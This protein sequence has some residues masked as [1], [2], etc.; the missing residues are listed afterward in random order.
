[1]S[2][3]SLPDYLFYRLATPND[4][5]TG[6]ARAITVIGMAGT[7][8]VFL[9]VVWLLHHVNSRHWV[10]QHL[11]LLRNCCIVLFVS[12]D[13]LTYRRYRSAQA[14]ARLHQRWGTDGPRK[15]MLKLLAVLL[16]CVI[17][18]GGAYKILHPLEL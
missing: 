17:F 14:Y 3:L 9:P 2:L 10:V 5:A 7:L 18:F 11:S 12:L 13:Y 16:F 1:M 15:R 6:G 8:A 4:R